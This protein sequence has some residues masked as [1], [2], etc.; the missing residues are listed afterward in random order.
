MNG[1]AVVSTA[2]LGQVPTGWQFVETGDFNGDGTSD[3]L[4]FSPTFGVVAMWFMSNGQIAQPAGVG[5]VGSGWMIQSI[6]AD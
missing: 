4:W 5:F 1:A 2:G 6:N 3:V